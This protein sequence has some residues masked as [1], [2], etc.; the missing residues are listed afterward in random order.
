[1]GIPSKSSI[2]R[3]GKFGIVGI[4][5]TLIDF[6]IFNLLTTDTGLGLVPAN[7]IS[8]TIAMV[9][10]FMANKRVV[11]RKQDGSTVMQA[12]IFFAFT[13][14]GLYV[15]QNGTI[16]ILTS[17]W[18]W[19]INVFVATVHMLGIPD[20]NAFLIKNGAKAVATVVSLSWNYVVYKKVVFK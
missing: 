9:F 3:V 13:A 2:H 16:Y 11:F 10:S 1:M 15:L 17:V 20:H 12:V 18:T 5:N 19:P 6:V 8:T 4:L 7:V 14:F